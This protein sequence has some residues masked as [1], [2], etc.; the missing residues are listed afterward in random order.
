MKEGRRKGREH[1][2]KVIPKY[3]SGGVSS[4]S[5]QNSPS[6]S[7]HR[8]AKPGFRWKALWIA[9]LVAANVA[10]Y[11]PVRQHEFVNWYVGTLVPVIGLMQVGSQPMADRYTYVPLV[12]L[13]IIVAWGVPDLLGRWQ[14]RR[15]VLPAAAGIVIMACAIA[16]RVQVQYWKNN[17]AFSSRRVVSNPQENPAK[18]YEH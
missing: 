9:L 8:T 2:A 18:Y 14:P 12:G 11:L 10:V 16:A 13:F 4:A 3:R 1:K 6:N 17:V 7:T 5:A 15:I